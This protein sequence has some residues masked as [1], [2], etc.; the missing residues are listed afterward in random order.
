MAVVVV[1]ALDQGVQCMHPVQT[2]IRAASLSFAHYRTH[3]SEFHALF[4]FALTNCLLT[5]V[6]TNIKNP[7]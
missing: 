5:Q 3:F 1:L 6:D 2:T 4:L 7:E